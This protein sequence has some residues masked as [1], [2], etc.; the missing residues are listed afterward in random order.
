MMKL[1][2]SKRFSLFA[3]STASKRFRFLRN[4]I[5]SSACSGVIALSNSLFLLRISR[6]VPLTSAPL[7]STGSSLLY[8]SKGFLPKA[9]AILPRAILLSIVAAANLIAPHLRL[10]FLCGKSFRLL[11]FLCDNNLHKDVFLLPSY[12]RQCLIC[13]NAHQLHSRLQIF[14]PQSFDTL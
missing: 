10:I 5:T 9:A 2:T 4:S 13:Y 12:H 7:T 1:G 3:I 6:S 11:H 8:L 14:Y